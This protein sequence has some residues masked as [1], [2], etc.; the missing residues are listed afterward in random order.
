MAARRM[1][2]IGTSEM[3]L[4]L[5]D[6]LMSIKPLISHRFEVLPDGGMPN[7]L[8]ITG[9]DF[10]DKLSPVV[11]FAKRLVHCIDE[12]VILLICHSRFSMSGVW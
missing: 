1:V 2:A 7:H 9:V 8:Q 10:W 11:D 5:P 6:Q 4:R 12:M 3:H